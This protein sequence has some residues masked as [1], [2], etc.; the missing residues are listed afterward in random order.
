M[1]TFF[2][3]INWTLSLSFLALGITFRL[4]FQTPDSYIMFLLSCM[5]FPPLY[6]LIAARSGQ[7]M[8]WWLR[9]T[10][11][12][13]VLFLIFVIMIDSPSN[14]ATSYQSQLPKSVKQKPPLQRRKLIWKELTRAW[15]ADDPR[16]AKHA[17]LKKYKLT[18]EELTAIQDEALSNN[19]LPVNPTPTPRP[20][21]NIITQI[22]RTAAHPLGK[23]LVD[24]V[25]LSRTKAGVRINYLAPKNRIP[26]WTRAEIIMNA[27]AI[28]KQLSLHPDLQMVRHY[29]IYAWLMLE[30]ESGNKVEQQA[31]IIK[32]SQAAAKK[33]N[34]DRVADAQFQQIVQWEGELWIHPLLLKK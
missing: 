27:R 20:P 22:V 31:V 9:A 34:W 30:D 25:M 8:S 29:E 33:I 7:Q 5:F 13:L 28:I 15:K 12:L 24:L 1:K 32:L 2:S 10:L 26:A 17:L 23:M 19:W 3:M 16:Q 18:N 21:K 11:L 14:H 6:A 4:R